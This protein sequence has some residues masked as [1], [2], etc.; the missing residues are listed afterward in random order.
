MQSDEETQRSHLNIDALVLVPDPHDHGDWNYDRNGDDGEYDD[1]YTDDHD[2]PLVTYLRQIG[3][4]S[5]LTREGEQALCAAMNEAR[6]A[7]YKALYSNAEMLVLYFGGILSRIKGN[8]VDEGVVHYLRKYDSSHLDEDFVGTYFVLDDADG[9]SGDDQTTEQRKLKL[10]ESFEAF[11]Q[12]ITD[13]TRH[14]R[15]TRRN[16]AVNKNLRTKERYL[17]E[18][19]EDIEAILSEAEKWLLKT[20]YEHGLAELVRD[21]YQY[22]SEVKEGKKKLSSEVRERYGLDKRKCSVFRDRLLDYVLVTMKQN[23]A[24]YARAS[25]SYSRFYNNLIQANLRLV[26]NIAK[27]YTNRGVLFADLIQEGNIGLMKAADKFEYL[28]GFKFSTYATWWI[29]QAITRGI[30]DNGRTIRVPVHVVEVANRVHR[31][32]SALRRELQR[33]PTRAELAEGLEI[34]IEK[35]DT[36]LQQVRDPIS[37]ETPMGSD[38]VHQLMDL[39]EGDAPDPIEMQRQA[40]LRRDV[41][42]ALSSLKPR[43]ERVLRLRYGVGASFENVRTI[44]RDGHTLEEIGRDCSLTRERIRQIEAAAL[45]KLRGRFQGEFKDL[46]DDE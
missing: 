3:K 9:E 30:A 31:I 33:E 1:R 26:V 12:A 34:S 43:D 21:T 45:E 18:I 37:L 39:I 38:G 40:D 42:K 7:Y 32:E 16:Y 23:R 10:N 14:L 5:L 36:L 35:L 13:K 46:V 17:R 15:D 41:S 28:R 6:S 25:H 22:L 19:T 27:K 4:T 29:R 24:V 11:Y 8:E 44:K 2:D 20:P